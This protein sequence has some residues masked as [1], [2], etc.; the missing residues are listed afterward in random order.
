MNYFQITFLCF[1]VHF[2]AFVTKFVKP[3]FKFILKTNVDL[4][5][6]VYLSVPCNPVPILATPFPWVLVVYRNKP[7]HAILRPDS[8]SENRKISLATCHRVEQ[9]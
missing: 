8:A 6:R 4:C 7:S 2:F 1:F 9:C 5:K 3:G